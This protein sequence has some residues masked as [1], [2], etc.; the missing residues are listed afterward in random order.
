MIFPSSDGKFDYIALLPLSVNV[1]MALNKAQ[2]GLAGRLWSILLIAYACVS[3]YY[4]GTNSPEALY[5]VYI[6][7]AVTLVALIANVTFSRP[8]A[9]LALALLIAAVARPEA[10]P[11]L[12]N[13]GT[14]LVCAAPFV[15]YVGMS[16]RSREIS[17]ALIRRFRDTMK[18][19]PEVSERDIEKQLEEIAKMPKDRAEMKM[20]GMIDGVLA[21]RQGDL[22]VSNAE[23]RAV[24]TSELRGRR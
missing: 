14:A 13:T 7:I 1:Y 24:K 19:V 2:P 16:I 6:N 23:L 15:I 12:D 4:L 22:V 20:K 11:R 5:F 8:V 3:A 17:P 18:T 10:R 9:V 21:I